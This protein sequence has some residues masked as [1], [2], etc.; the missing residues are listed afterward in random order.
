MLAN[1]SFGIMVFHPIGWILMG[2]VI[3]IEALLLRRRL[4]GEPW[5]HNFLAISAIANAASGLLGLLLS[6]T[7]TSGWWLVLWIPWVTANEVSRR[8]LG[9]FLPFLA[10]TFAA[11][12]VVEWAVVVKLLPAQAAA[13]ILRVELMA[14]LASSVLLY[15]A[16]S[17]MGGVPGL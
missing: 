6:L 16:F 3:V 4:G 7:L 13:R 5:R 10:L 8:Q 15:A 14:N 9:E 12:V 2:L 11:S 17:A 1:V